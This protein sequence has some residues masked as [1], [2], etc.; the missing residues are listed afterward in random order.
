MTNHTSKIVFGNKLEEE[1][2]RSSKTKTKP[3]D[4]FK[5]ILN[6]IPGYKVPFSEVPRPSKCQKQVPISKE[7]SLLVVTDIHS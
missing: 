4:V 6:M 1:I 3:K 7:K 2:Y 5:G